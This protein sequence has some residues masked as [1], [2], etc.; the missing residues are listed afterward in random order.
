[1]C[2]EDDQW[3]H[4]RRLNITAV[5][6]V[7]YRNVFISRRASSTAY[8]CWRSLF[9]LKSRK[10]Y[11]SRANGHSVEIAQL[12]SSHLHRRFGAM[13]SGRSQYRSVQKGSIYKSLPCG[14]SLDFPW[15]LLNGI[16]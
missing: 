15:A 14:I 16:Y 3:T 5:I 8:K 10:G 12:G 13:N 9:G 4:E 11:E 2:V 6:G 7:H 1:M